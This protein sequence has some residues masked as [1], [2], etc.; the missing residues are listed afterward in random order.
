MKDWWRKHEIQ[1]LMKKK[2]FDGSGGG[3]LVMSS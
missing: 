3:G 1:G 2:S